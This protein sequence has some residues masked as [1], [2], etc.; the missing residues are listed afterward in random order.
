MCTELVSKNFFSIMYKYDAD[1]ITSEEIT[2]S[3]NIEYDKS[4][5]QLW[6]LCPLLKKVSQTGQCGQKSYHLGH[7]LGVGGFCF[8]EVCSL[9]KENR[10]LHI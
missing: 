10:I 4:D 6:L 1:Q 8:L 3:E 7:S 5:A 2:V 9:S